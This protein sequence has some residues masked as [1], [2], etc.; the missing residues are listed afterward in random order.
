[1]KK[2]RSACFT[3][4]FSTLFFFNA[5][6]LANADTIDS[7]D[8][9]LLDNNADELY[10]ETYPLQI[11]D[12]E[13]LNFFSEEDRN[14]YINHVMPSSSKIQPMSGIK[15]RETFISSQRYYGKFVG[16]NS[17]TPS[18][19]YA[20]SYTISR[21]KNFSF[22]TGYT[23]DGVSANLSVAQSYGVAITLPAES[24]RSSKLAGKADLTISK[25]KIEAY[26][27]TTVTQTFY[28]LRTGSVSNFTNYVGY[29]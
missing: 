26:Y 24:S 12:S 6:S 22:S 19:S 2:L 1:M 4:L 9:I 11:N 18:W 7:P 16:Y 29:R 5:S 28:V 20:S 3:L 14:F 13:F 21:G 15:T 23:Y 17:M 25:Y 8:N 10:V 27:G